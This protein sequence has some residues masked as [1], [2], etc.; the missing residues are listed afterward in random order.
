MVIKVFST[1]INSWD[2]SILQAGQYAADVTGVSVYT[3][4]KWIATYYLSLVGVWLDEINGEFME[5][6]L[7]SERGRSCRSPGSILYYEESRLH[8]QEFIHKNSEASKI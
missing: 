7:S 8:A 1:A 2:M 5:K 3:A 4:R 6:L